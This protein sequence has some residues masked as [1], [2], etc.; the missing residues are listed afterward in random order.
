MTN[1]YPT[2]RDCEHG[3]IRTREGAYVND[4]IVICPYVP[5]WAKYGR[6]EAGWVIYQKDCPQVSKQ[7]PYQMR[8][9]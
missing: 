9:W 7:E 2:C 4:T 8:L 3:K 1:G 5:K 6:Y